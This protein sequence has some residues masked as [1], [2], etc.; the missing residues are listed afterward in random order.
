[1]LP[2]GKW[3]IFWKR[4]CFIIS[5]ISTLIFPAIGKK[6]LKQIGLFLLCFKMFFSYRKTQRIWKIEIPKKKIK[7]TLPFQ[8]TF[9]F[10]SF[11]YGRKTKT[12]ND[13]RITKRIRIGAGQGREGLD[14][15]VYILLE[16]GVNRPQFFRPPYTPPY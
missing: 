9:I 1:M 4:H 2:P 5:L 8:V 11:F 14:K 3:S 16:Q 10:L 7:N 13:S 15:V 6:I 12:T